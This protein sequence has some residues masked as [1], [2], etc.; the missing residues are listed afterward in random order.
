MVRYPYLLF[1]A[2]DTLLDFEQNGWKAFRQL[3]AKYNFPCNEET[4]EIYESYNQPL[5]RK[6]ERGLITKDFLKIERFRLFLEY[7]HRSESPEEVNA[8]FLSFLGTGSFLTPYAE[9]V[10]KELSQNHKLY[11]ITNSVESVHVDRMRQSLINP[12]IE[13]SFISEVIGYEKPHTQYFDYVFSHIPGITKDNCLLIGDSL[14]SDMQG[15]V[16]FG[17][18]VCWYN[19]KHLTPI[20]TLPIDYEIHDL[21]ELPAI[22]N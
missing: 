3:C 12:Y 20:G 11:V 15:G 18:P 19:P 7:L 1:D 5:W 2:D 9:D 10:C 21:R 17:I 16:N 6:V 13:T 14:T 4:H 22:V 8:S